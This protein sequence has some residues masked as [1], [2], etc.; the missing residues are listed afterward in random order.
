MI[1]ENLI[2]EPGLYVAATPIGNLK[3]IT[4][5]VIETL[6][7]ADLILCEDTR[8]TAKLCQAF[9]ITT[10]RLAYHDH[11]GEKM[12]PVIFQRLEAG[13]AICL[14]SDAGTPLISDPG[15]KL[16]HEVIKNDFHVTALPGACAAITALSIAGLA[17]DQFLFA[18]FVPTK[19]G[20]REK[21]LKNLISIET[22][23]IFYETAPRLR[24][25]LLAM[26]DVFGPRAFVVARELTKRH[27]EIVRGV[28]GQAN[29]ILDNMVLKGEIVILVERAPHEDVTDDMLEDFLRTVLE[30]VSVKEAA[31]KASEKWGIPR[32]DAYQKALA[33][34]GELG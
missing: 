14:V 4:L 22:T 20:A 29:E 30:Q 3:D 34:K 12:R 33:L 1:D 16:V 7:A 18:G 13:E 11:N 24:D 19:E 17:S 28:L 26:A 8:H 27:E 10:K 5:R 32:R 9:G 23:L 21:F 15:Y 2:L 25:C 6:K 31:A